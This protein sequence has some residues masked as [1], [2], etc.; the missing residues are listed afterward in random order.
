[1][2]TADLI[3]ALSADNDARSM[4]PGRAL[5]LASGPAIAI[6]LG[7]HLSIL[8]LR[9]HLFSLLGDPRI[10]FKIGLTILLA[11]VSCRMA[12]RLA[13][14]GVRLRSSDLWLAI[15]PALL[16]A[17]VLAELLS[18]P[19]NLW[20]QKMFGSNALFC[21]ASI[22]FLAAAPLVAALLALRHGA[23]ENPGLAGAAAGLFAGAIGA[24]C[25]ATHC[26]DDSPLF[27]AAWY[28][29]AI[30]FVAAAG[31]LAGRRLLRW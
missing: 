2:K 8:G 6:A 4:A 25:Y 12:L 29:L 5:A 3:R 28:S 19:Q 16:A 15:V 26:P 11:V 30:G 17:A 24:A 7:L 21:L 23:P 18:V 9:P 27:V 13:T 22:P 14:P 31:A 10:L 1:V 20:G